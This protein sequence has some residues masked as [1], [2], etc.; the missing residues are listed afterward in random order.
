MTISVKR[1]DLSKYDTFAVSGPNSNH[2]TIAVRSDH[3]EN[4]R[5]DGE[6]RHGIHLLI[7]GDF[8]PW[9]YYWSHAGGAKDTWWSWL[10]NTDRDYMM[11]KLCGR[12]GI[13]EF[14]FGA[15]KAYVIKEIIRMR[16]DFT[17]DAHDARDAYNQ[18]ASLDDEGQ[19]PFLSEVG[20]LTYRPHRLEGTSRH[21]RPIFPEYYEMY[22]ERVT[23]RV[24][25]FWKE[26]W[27]P[28]IEEANRTEGFT[29]QAEVAA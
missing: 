8:G 16:R 22:Q 26:I 23:P 29:K 2:V 1:R 17:L 4:C 5:I 10:H 12:N 13:K 11:G 19:Y 6:S 28:F 24:E 7:W 3:I 25:F 9:E 15:S 14:D 21:E 27:R 20:G 18:I